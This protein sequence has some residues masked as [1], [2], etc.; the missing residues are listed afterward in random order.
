MK[1]LEIFN[2]LK[3]GNSNVC[4]KFVN[5]IIKCFYNCQCRSYIGTREKSVFAICWL[6]FLKMIL[7]DVEI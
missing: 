6:I 2:S 3:R 5:G 4:M 1:I 7:F